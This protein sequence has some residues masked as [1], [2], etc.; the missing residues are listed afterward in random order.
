MKR[1]DFVRSGVAGIAGGVIGTPTVLAAGSGPAIPTGRSADLP[2]GRARSIIFFAYDGFSHEDL[3]TA[4]YF[5]QRHLGMDRL[6]IENLLATGPSG[7]SLTHSADSVVTDSAAASSAWASGVKL[8]NGRVGVDA[9]GHALT[10]IMELARRQGRATGLITSTRLTHAT[11]A[12]WV[13]SVVDR[14]DED[15]IASQY[16]DFAPDVLLGGG[17]VHFDSA[18][19]SDGR[20]LFAGFRAAGYEVLRSADD[21]TRSN[22]SRVLGAFTPGHLPYEIDRIHQS[23][24]APTLADLTR[25]GLAILDGADN[26]FVVQIEAGRIDHANHDNDPAA[27]VWDVIGADE[28]LRA[29][30]AFVDRTPGTLMIVASDHGTG[31][32]VIYGFGARYSG[33]DRVFDGLAGRRSSQEHL[34][35]VLGPRPDAVTL[36]AA[37]ES[38]LGV[39]I[40]ADE[41]H[42]AIEVLEKRQEILHHPAAGGD[43][44]TMLH[45][46]LTHRDEDGRLRLNFN[47]ATGAHTSGPVPLA[48]YGSGVT[49]AGLGVVDNTELFHWMCHALGIER[50]S[51]ADRAAPGYALAA[52]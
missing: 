9:E 17:A 32:G 24:D 23:A 11:P 48:L 3:G 18:T 44:L 15:I 19:R 38:V 41:A 43:R 46:L 25:R 30:M 20:D 12:G 28:A 37:A 45:L 26:G 39:P 1:R 6:A 51:G 33:T 52:G 47:Y 2:V 16:L 13:A 50:S 40:S 5:A 34:L 7:L 22:A 29:A 8:L 36:Q 49:T 27:M 35:R 42:R 14:D 10:R 21:L 4:R 31:G